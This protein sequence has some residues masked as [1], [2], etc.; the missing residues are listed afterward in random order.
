MQNYR[1][2]KFFLFKISNLYYFV[3]E[4]QADDKVFIPL[5][6]IKLVFTY[7]ELISS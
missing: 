5:N 7:I 1:E 6:N 4:V 2:I 3:M